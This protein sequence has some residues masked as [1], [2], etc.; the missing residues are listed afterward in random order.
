MSL[1][2]VDQEK[3]KRDGICVSECPVGIIEIKSDDALPEP[4]PEA[5]EFCINCGHCVAVC[6][7]GALSLATMSLQECAP[8]DM[9]ALPGPEHIENFLKARR[10][11]RTYKSKPVAREMLTR[12]IDSARY[13]PS[14]HNRQPVHWLVIQGE[15]EV[16]RLAGVTVDWM[17]AMIEEQSPIAELLHLD[18]PI[19]AWERGVDR[20]LRSAPSL[21]IAHGEEAERTA[22]SSCIIALTYLELAAFA[23]GLGACWAGYF[24]AAASLFPP[25]QQTLALPKGHLCFGAIMVGY[26]KFNYQRV[27]LRNEASVTWR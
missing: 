5:W 6:P 24:N 19:A 25:M 9:S 21:V 14:G 15:D 1:F 10:S 23:N 2:T 16:R 22:Q 17:R 18:R 3:C 7:H 4:I 12:M 13:A 26:P 11:I 8:T 27:P 20:V